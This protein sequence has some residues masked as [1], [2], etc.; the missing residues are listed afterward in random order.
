MAAAAGLS[1]GLRT[2]EMAKQTHLAMLKAAMA[3]VRSGPENSRPRPKRT[4]ASGPFSYEKIPRDSGS[5]EDAARDGKPV[6]LEVGRTT[7]K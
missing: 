4:H 6:T 7:P 5:S 1:G 2:S 3:V